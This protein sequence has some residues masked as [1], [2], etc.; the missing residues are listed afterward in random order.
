MDE[1]WLELKTH[2]LCWEMLVVCIVEGNTTIHTACDKQ[3]SIWRVSNSLDWLIKLSEGKTVCHTSLFNVKDSH[4]S[5]SKSAGKDCKVRMG[6]HTKSLIDWTRVLNNLV[7]IVYVPQSNCLVVAHCDEI[8]PG[9][10]IVHAQNSL[11]M[12]PQQSRVPLI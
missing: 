4:S 5:R 1:L 8:L 7:E 9:H 2:H 3:V 6:T 12:R 10:V 11:R